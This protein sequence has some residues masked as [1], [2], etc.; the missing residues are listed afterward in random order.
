MVYHDSEFEKGT[1]SSPYLVLDFLWPFYI[2]CLMLKSPEKS[3]HQFIVEVDNFHYGIHHQHADLQRID[4]SNLCS[5]HFIR[6]N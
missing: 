5:L 2:F 6:L 4:M 3:T 1:L